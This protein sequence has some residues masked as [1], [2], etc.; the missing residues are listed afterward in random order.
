MSVLAVAIRVFLPNLVEIERTVWKLFKQLFANLASLGSHLR[1]QKYN[2]LNL[3]SSGGGKM[4]IPA[5]FGANRKNR[6]EANHFVVKFTFRRRPSC[7]LKKFK[8]AP[9]GHL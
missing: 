8:I 4:I 1:F 2:I 3:R 9:G 5:E 6:L 7:I